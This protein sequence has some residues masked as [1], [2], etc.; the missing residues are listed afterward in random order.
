MKA[1]VRVTAGDSNSPLAILGVILSL[2]Q[3]SLQT[4][5]IKQQ[6]T[7]QDYLVTMTHAIWITLHHISPDQKIHKDIMQ[8]L[9]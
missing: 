9:P 3:I 5:F 1:L 8:T 4:V 7:T 6:C 2:S